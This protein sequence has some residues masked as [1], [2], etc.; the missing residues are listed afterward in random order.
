[1][2]TV[3]ESLWGAATA[4]PV[5][6]YNVLSGAPP[7]V[8][9]TIKVLDGI[10]GL[11]SPGTTTLLL[12]HPGAGKSSFLK[13]LTGRLSEPGKLGGRIDYSGL[14]A[15]SLAKGGFALGQLV[16]YVSGERAKRLNA[17]SARVA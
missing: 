13:A 5:A 1:M 17:R 7:P 8:V 4:I 6:I 2:T 15:A 16:Q 11:I 10:S 12:G 3:A 14:D 9:H